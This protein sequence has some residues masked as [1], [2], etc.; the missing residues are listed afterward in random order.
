MADMLLYEMQSEKTCLRDFRPGLTQTELYS[1]RTNSGIL[2]EEGEYYK[3]NENKGAFVI[4]YVICRFSH[5]AAQFIQ[6]KSDYID[7]SLA[8]IT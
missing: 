2:E 1:Y 3:C 8:A 5:D 6:N 4:V 7:T